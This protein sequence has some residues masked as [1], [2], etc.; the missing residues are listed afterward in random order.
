VQGQRL[1]RVFTNVHP[2]GIGRLWRVGEPF[3]EFAAR[4]LPRTRRALP[5]TS[6]LLHRLHVTKSRRTEYDHLMLQLHDLAKADAEYQSGAPQQRIDFPAGSTW[7][8]FS[9][10]VLHAAMSGQYLFEQTYYLDPKGLSDP[11][12]SPLAVLETL[13]GRKLIA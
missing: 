6:W 10:Q 1:L 11:A 12:S 13:T 8:T 7:I 3:R 9:D 2:D 5:G 4:F